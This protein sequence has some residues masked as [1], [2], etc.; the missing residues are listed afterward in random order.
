M[1]GTAVCWSLHKSKNKI[2][3]K[4]DTVNGYSI[5]DGTMGVNLETIPREH[6]TLGARGDAPQSLN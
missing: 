5:E 1:S 2:V 6:L 4:E 3:R